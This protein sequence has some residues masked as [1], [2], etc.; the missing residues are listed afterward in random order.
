MSLAFTTTLGIVIILG[1]FAK[2]LFDRAGLPEALPLVA[3][4]ALLGRLFPSEAAALDSPFMSSL[5]LL[6]LAAI[7]FQAGLELGRGEG[8]KGLGRAILLALLSF[9]ASSFLL[10]CALSIGLDMRGPEAWA[11]AAALA[12]TSADLALPVLAKL[13]GA[14]FEPL[15]PLVS[16][17][18]ALSVVLA[19]LAVLFL[20]GGG[21]ETSLGGRALSLALGA[22]PAFLL[23]L[24]W[25]R[26]LPSLAAGGL[27]YLLTAGLALLLMGALEQ[28]GGSGAAAVIVFGAT[29]GRGPALAALLLRGRQGRAGSKASS[30]AALLSLGEAQGRLLFLFRSAFYLSLG[31]L[32]EWPGEDLRVWLGILIAAVAVILA[33]EIAVQLAGWAGSIP[34]RERALLRFAAPRG[35]ESAV[36]ITLLGP[37]L[38]AG[39]WRS[40]AVA[41]LLVSDLR[42]G[43]GAARLRRE[44][45]GRKS[46]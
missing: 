31:L 44:A 3:I 41:V 13:D 26:L 32:L 30:E 2:A 7:L 42:M 27:S 45:R 23:G 34:G 24:L 29:L 46:A 22:G 25:L 9:A 10:Y 6:A 21:G 16:L 15:R 4:G 20:K 33:R 35:L 11:V 38:G 8:R 28:A 5:G 18:S 17:E 39:P 36:L 19:A 40:L 43:A 14:E 37:W 12:C 1:F